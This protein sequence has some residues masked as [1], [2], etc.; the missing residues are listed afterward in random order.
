MAR[1][2]LR[3]GPLRLTEGAP[4]DALEDADRVFSD[5]GPL[6]VG[7][8]SEVRAVFDPRLLRHAAMKRIRPDAVHPRVLAR[9]VEEARIH[10]Q[11][12]HPNLV[13]VHEFGA[14]AEG[15]LYLNMQRVSGQTLTRFID[16][17]GTGRLDKEVL[18]K[19]IPWLMRVCDALELVR[20]LSVLP[21]YEPSHAEGS[22]EQTVPPEPGPASMVTVRRTFG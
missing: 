17:Q 7:G 3:T 11:L 2:T 19:V 15:G 1:D 22:R 4:E 12:Q 10:G 16:D 9:F 8:T 18:A 14:D 21:E 13:P 6:G 5:G 20:R